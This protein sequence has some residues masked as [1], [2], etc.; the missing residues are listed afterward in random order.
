MSAAVPEAKTSQ[1][2]E[3]ISLMTWDRSPIS[4]KSPSFF[5]TEMKRARAGEQEQTR[6][7]PMRDIT[8]DVLFLDPKMMKPFNEGVP[9]L[10]TC[11]L[12][13]RHWISGDGVERWS[14]SWSVQLIIVKRQFFARGPVDGIFS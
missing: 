9:V 5:I 2:E 3:E 11:F 7:L 12:K 8:W 13:T 14:T 10:E 6:G 1:K 4:T